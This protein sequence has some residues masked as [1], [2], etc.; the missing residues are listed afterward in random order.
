MAKSPK[1]GNPKVFKEAKAKNEGTVK[2]ASGGKVGG[3]P[4]SASSAKHPYTGAH[5]KGGKC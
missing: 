3:S 1:E 2:R 5:S 4:Y